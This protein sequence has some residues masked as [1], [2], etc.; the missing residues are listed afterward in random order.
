VERNISDNH[1]K[2]GTA[3]STRLDNLNL[4]VTLYN[5]VILDAEREESEA[6]DEAVQLVL[7]GV[8]VVFDKVMRQ[9]Y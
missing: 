1:H 4:Q 8:N 2:H 7:Q 6:Y 5:L 9:D 3:L